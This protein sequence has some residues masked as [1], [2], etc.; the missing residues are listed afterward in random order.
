[1]PNGI[2][3]GCGARGC[4]EAICSGTGIARRFIEKINGGASSAVTKKIQSVEQITAK[5]ITDAA[6]EG[7][8]LASDIWDET[9]F[10]LSIGL[11]NVI[12][13]FEPEAIILGG[14]VSMTGEQLFRPLRR[15]II[16]RTKIFSAEGVRI[17]H[18][19]LGVES[20]IYGALALVNS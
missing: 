5:H 12:V 3:C 1:M 16:E 10:Y 15:E 4:L 8:R 20:G 11:A 6:A 13:I 14:G 9:I 2:K 19:G 7:D 18:A 17:V